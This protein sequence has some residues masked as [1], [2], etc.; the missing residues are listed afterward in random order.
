M[1]PAQIRPSNTE[2][3][4]GKLMPV[5]SRLMSA[6]SGVGALVGL[7][8]G[9]DVSSVTLPA[10]TLTVEFTGAGVGVVPYHG[11]YCHSGTW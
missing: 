8:E 5:R 6:A 9:G 4:V 10:V 11:V 2:I 3:V 7:A 1:N